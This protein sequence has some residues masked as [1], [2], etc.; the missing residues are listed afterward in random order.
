MACFV[1][2]SCSFQGFAGSV[3]VHTWSPKR[4]YFSELLW[5]SRELLCF[6][7]LCVW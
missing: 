3:R 7:G 5:F 6:W 1:L 4:S 2:I